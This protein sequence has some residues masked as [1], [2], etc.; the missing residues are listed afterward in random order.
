MDKET[1]LLPF[2]YNVSRPMGFSSSQNSMSP[3]SSLSSWSSIPVSGNPGGPGTD[4]LP[5]I[6]TSSMMQRTT[7]LQ[8]GNQRMMNGNEDWYHDSNPTTERRENNL[9]MRSLS[10][11]VGQSADF[12]NNNMI[13]DINLES[14]DKMDIDIQANHNEP[15]NNLLGRNLKRLWGTQ[16][17]Q[18][19]NSDMVK[20]LFPDANNNESIS[21]SFHT[22]GSNKR[23]HSQYK[24]YGPLILD[25]HTENITQDNLPRQSDNSLWKNKKQKHWKLPTSLSS[26]P[27]FGPSPKDHDHLIFATQFTSEADELVFYPLASSPPCPDEMFDPISTNNDLFDLTQPEI[28]H[29]NK[30]KVNEDLENDRAKLATQNALM[31]IAE[32]VEESNTDINLE[33]LG[34]VKLPPEIG[35]LSNMIVIPTTLKDSTLKPTNIQIYLAHNRLSQLHPSLFAIQSL[36]VLSLRGNKLTYIPSSI[37]NLVNL[38]E[39]SISGNHITTLPF[40]ILKLERLEV[41]SIRPNPLLEEKPENKTKGTMIKEDGIIDVHDEKPKFLYADDL[42]FIS[43]VIGSTVSTLAELVLREIGKYNPTITEANRWTE[44]IGKIYGEQIN[45][46]KE[47]VINEEKCSIC[48]ELCVRPIAQVIEWWN[49]G[50]QKRLPVKREFCSGRCVQEWSNENISSCN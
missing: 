29:I 1:P 18:T 26:S 25:T 15:I 17:T 8:V 19:V 22:G 40:G 43:P 49:L 10:Y 7:S 16:G 44:R 28:V 4:S 42:E 32:C 34:L 50:G 37:C 47:R 20:R 31:V 27:V 14:D 6:K 38:R 21:G 36:T 24:D 48:N 35:D 33:S 5:Q 41:L 46:A 13:G 11:N 2:A 45:L 39:L 23:V 3:Q 30:E 12:T 9:M